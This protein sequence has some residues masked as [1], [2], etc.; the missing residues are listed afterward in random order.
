[1]SKNYICLNKLLSSRQ[2]NFIVIHG[3][4]T[5]L[6]AK[7]LSKNGSKQDD[8]EHILTNTKVT[9]KYKIPDFS[10]ISGP[11]SMIFFSKILKI[12]VY[13]TGASI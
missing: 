3:L 10:A 4:L 9:G 5:K 12:Y 1:M 8:L 2:K 6:L 13:I 11:N 7:N